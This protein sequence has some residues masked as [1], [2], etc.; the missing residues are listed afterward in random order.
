MFIGGF[1][2]VRAGCRYPSV[3]I[4]GGSVGWDDLAGLA[5]D[6]QTNGRRCVRFTPTIPIGQWQSSQKS[7]STAPY[8]IINDESPRLD[9]GGR[10]AQGQWE[11]VGGVFTVDE[12][13]FSLTM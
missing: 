8:D 12:L 11:D 6:W 10:Q 13:A 5:R 3:T 7:Q 9:P 4:G 2:A 1:E